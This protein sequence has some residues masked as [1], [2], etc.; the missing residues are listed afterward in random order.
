MQIITIAWIKTNTYYNNILIFFF[1]CGVNL[2]ISQILAELW[3]K[4]SIFIE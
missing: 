2:D 4:R 1:K 3:N